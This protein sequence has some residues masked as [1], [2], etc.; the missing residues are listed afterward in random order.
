MTNPTDNA[1]G[2]KTTVLP[3]PMV[4]ITEREDDFSSLHEELE[5]EIQPRNFIE[6]MYV[7]DIAALLWEIIRLRRFKT[8]MLNGALRVALQNVLKQILFK[9]E[10]VEKPDYVLEAE[11]LADDWFHSQK[12]KNQVAKLL[13]QFLL[14]ESAIE[15]EGFRLMSSELD[16]LDRM[17]TLA[18]V[19][20]DKALHSIAD[21]RDSLARRLRQ[22]SQ[23][24]LDAEAVRHIEH[25]PSTN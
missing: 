19:R 14:D 15:A 3:Y 20:R 7:G 10:F 24:I 6:R 11:T 18:E 4:L 17:L 1:A 8:A 21:Y 23:Q 13:R 12:A 22:S 25:T 5:Q 2:E 9:P 16:G